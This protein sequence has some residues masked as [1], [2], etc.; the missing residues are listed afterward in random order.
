MTNEE[1]ER[2]LAMTLEKIEDIE[3]TTEMK[4]NTNKITKFPL[5]K[6]SK[7]I[8][9]SLAAVV[10]LG[11]SAYAAVQL[12]P[13]IRNYFGI[14]TNTQKEIAKELTTNT[15][16]TAKNNGI[17]TKICQVMSDKRGFVADV[18][19]KGLPK[20]L[21]TLD[22]EDVALG[23]EGI[24]Q[25]DLT[26]STSIHMGGIDGNVAH[27]LVAVKYDVIDGE[28]PDLNGRKVTFTLKNLCS[29]NGDITT[30]KIAKKGTW[31]MRWDLSIKD[32]AEAIVVNKEMSLFDSKV[33]WDSYE[34]SPMSLTVNFSVKK[35]GSEHL[36][37]TDFKKYIGTDRIVVQLTNGKR[38]DSRFS[39][40][41]NINWD[42]NYV[43]GFDEIVNP[44][45]VASIS[46]G[47]ETVKLKDLTT[48]IEYKTFTSKVGNF[49]LELP[50]DFAKVLTMKEKANVENKDTHCKEDRIDFIANKGGVEITLFTI[51][52]LYTEDNVVGTDDGDPMLIPI[53]D[54][55]N[56]KYALK[57]CELSTE[58]ELNTYAEFLNTY[59]SDVLPG[60]EIIK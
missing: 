23:I 46:F 54:Y 52:R 2:I 42:Q 19:L 44:E 14:E 3:R 34:L 33:V 35:Q 12:N 26:Y 45:N 15:S 16:A 47:G 51:H 9:A 17:T 59:D 13:T 28:M 55:G 37:E 38:I 18:E 60:F 40:D 50:E 31:K 24:S 21:D 11:G 29:R 30:L 25:D 36:T 32:H 7:V 53:V 39:D 48:K 27:F 56:E 6:S 1:K 10:I 49:T 57:F 4:N 8:A 43:L 5:K 41:L 20:D 22:F 58:E